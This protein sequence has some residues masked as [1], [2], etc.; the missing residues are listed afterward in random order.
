MHERVKS[1]SLSPC[2]SF[3]FNWKPCTIKRSVKQGIITTPT[4]LKHYNHLHICKRIKVAEEYDLRDSEVE[5]QLRRGHRLHSVGNYAITR[6]VVISGSFFR[7]GFWNFFLS[8]SFVQKEPFF[9]CKYCNKS[10]KKNYDFAN[11][12]HNLTGS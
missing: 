3:N 8:K 6:L 5:M 9:F 7:N 12:Q 10:A 4:P 1:P 2:G 11:R